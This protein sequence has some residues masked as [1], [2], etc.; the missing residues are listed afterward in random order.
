M[1]NILKEKSIL[2]DMSLLIVALIWGGGFIAVKD[3]LDSVSPFYI[4]AIRFSISVLIMLLVF[5]KKIKY[6]TKNYLFNG[7]IVGLLLFLGFA[8]QTIG[9]KYTT[10][11]KNAFLTGTNVV[12]VPFLYWI[13]S[14][15]RPDV[16]SLISAFL[17][18]IGIGMLTIDSGIHIGLGDGLTLLCAVFYAAHIVAVGFFARKV[19]VILLVIIQL[20][21]CALFSI[22]A[23]LIFEPVPQSLNSSTMF[24]LIYLGIFSTML[25]FIVQ[26]VAQK[27]TTSTH[28]AIILCLESVFGCILSVVMLHEIFTSKMILGCLTIFL[29]IITTET[30][31]KFVNYHHL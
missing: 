6:I 3:A 1:K 20:G 18:F 17:C 7:T 19:D 24:A 28:T 29:A 10:A 11:G 16:F 23:A 8:A 30:K 31:W 22:I 12:I 14:K 25:A 27:Y 26:N 15:K 13:I 21:A 4:M 9:M 5:R 2:A